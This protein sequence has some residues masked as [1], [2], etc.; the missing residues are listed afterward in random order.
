LEVLLL[1][2]AMFIGYIAMALFL[3]GRL[4]AAFNRPGLN[5]LWMT[6]IGLVILWIIG[7]VPFVGTAVK[8]IAAVL[9]FGAVLVTIFGSISRRRHARAV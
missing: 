7:W 8:S 1:G 4:A 2:C 3:G 9:G 6:S 5:L